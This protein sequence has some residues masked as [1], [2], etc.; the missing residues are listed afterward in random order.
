MIDLTEAIPKNLPSKLRNQ[1]NVIF[2]VVIFYL[3][4]YYNFLK[5]ITNERYKSTQFFTTIY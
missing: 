2:L 3:F 5:K 1:P 4:L